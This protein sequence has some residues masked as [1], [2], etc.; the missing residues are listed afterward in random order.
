MPCDGCEVADVKVLSNISL[1]TDQ[2]YTEVLGYEPSYLF[3]PSYGLLLRD[4][5]HHGFDRGHVAL[6]PLVSSAK[7]L[8]H[9]LLASLLTCARVLA[10]PSR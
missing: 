2:Y 8:S 10:P 7:S 4:D 1:S 9:T 6:W 5:L 3:E